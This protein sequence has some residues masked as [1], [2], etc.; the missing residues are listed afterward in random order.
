MGW[1][2]AVTSRLGRRYLARLLGNA[3][4]H[5]RSD[6]RP[7]LVS[8]F[9]GAVPS[10][11]AW[12]GLNPHHTLSDAWD[13]V[14]GV[15]VLGA[16]AGLVVWFIA[17]LVFAPAR[18]QHHTDN[19]LTASRRT[20][21][22]QR[23]ELTRLRRETRKA[24]NAVTNVTH[25]HNYAA[26]TTRQGDTP[27]SPTGLNTSRKTESVT[28]SGIIIPASVVLPPQNPPAPAGDSQD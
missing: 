19:R 22:S 27:S 6:A 14:S 16:A 13:Q 2:G 12:L 8:V 7:L 3:F 21:K 24:P 15:L 1:I 10:G 17:N 20:V 26:G 23:E 18:M 25:I 4:A 28:P 9:V 11:A 5:W